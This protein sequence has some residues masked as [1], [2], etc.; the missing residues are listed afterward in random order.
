MNRNLIAIVIGGLL[1]FAAAA[2]FFA[3]R[4]AW[5]QSR[6]PW[7]AM[8][9]T[10]PYYGPYSNQP[11]ALSWDQSKLAVVNPEAGT[12]S[13][14]QVAGDANTK[15]AEVPVGRAP[16]GVAWSADGSTLYVANQADGT[17]SSSVWASYTRAAISR[18]A[19]SR[20]APN[21]T[22]WY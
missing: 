5:S 6:V 7:R 15:T 12:V 1:A 2:I 17:V 10:A 13:I 4:V 16:A 18:P 22:E 3:P 9:A 11:L 19:P 14:F 20:S 21:R 8:A